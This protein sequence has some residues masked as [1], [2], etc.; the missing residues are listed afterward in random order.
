MLQRNRDV[1]ERDRTEAEYRSAM[2]CAT[3]G[4]LYRDEKKR[5]KPYQPKDFMPQ[6]EK[7]N[8]DKQSWEDQ[9][10]IIEML[11]AAMGGKDARGG[12]K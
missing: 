2:I 6:R 4:N 8:E 5:K 7:K 10:K 1:L 3:L 9:L 12:A 11:N